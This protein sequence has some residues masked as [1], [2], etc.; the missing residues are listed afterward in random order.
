M[1]SWAWGPVDVDQL[2]VT[3]DDGEEP[4]EPGEVV[5]DK[6]AEAEAMSEWKVVRKARGRERG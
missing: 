5:V 4:G 1:G 6:Q 3:A 2:N